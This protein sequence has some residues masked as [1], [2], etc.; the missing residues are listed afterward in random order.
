MSRVRAALRALLRSRSKPHAIAYWDRYARV[1]SPEFRGYEVAGD[2]RPEAYEFLGDEWGNPGHV[3]EILEEFVYPY[4]DGSTIAVEIG[5]GGGRVAGRLAPRVKHLYCLDVSVEMLDR[6]RTALADRENVSYIHVPDATLPADVLAAEPDF[7]FAFDVFVHLDLHTTWRYVK[8]IGDALRLGGHAF[9]H[10]TNLLTEPGWRRFAAQARHT[11][12]GH[13]FVSPEI[14]RILLSRAG[15]RIV[16]E[17]TEDASNFY[18][19]RDYLVV[20]QK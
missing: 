4:T 17:A 7:I 2:V 6:L 8:Q 15:L 14:V 20:V 3:T 13:Y 12:E 1:W 18:K 16:H 5:S 11:L 19:A 9:L 10:T